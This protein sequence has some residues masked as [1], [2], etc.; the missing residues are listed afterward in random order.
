M[1]LVTLCLI[2]SAS[3]SASTNTSLDAQEVES[4]LS[5]SLTQPTLQIFKDACQHFQDY[6][7]LLIPQQQEL[8]KAL[9]GQIDVLSD[10]REQI[11]NIESSLKKK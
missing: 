1:R 6:D 4:R 9:K 11:S 5:I 7:H 3:I 2:G 10:L 8:F